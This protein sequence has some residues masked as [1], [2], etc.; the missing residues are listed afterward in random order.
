MQF[1]NTRQPVFDNIFWSVRLHAR[2]VVGITPSRA[3]IAII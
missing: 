3:V 1:W 2:G